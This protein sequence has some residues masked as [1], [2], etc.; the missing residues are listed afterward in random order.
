MTGPAISAP[1][2]SA[3]LADPSRLLPPASRLI[4]PFL[5]PLPAPTCARRMQRSPRQCPNAANSSL[6]RMSGR[7]PLK[8]SMSSM[9]VQRQRPREDVGRDGSVAATSQGC[10]GHQKLGGA[11]RSVPQNLR[12]QCGPANALLSD[13][14][15][16]ELR[17]NKLSPSLWQF[18]M[19][20]TGNQNSK[21]TGFGCPRVGG[22]HTISSR[23]AS[24]STWVEGRRAWTN[25]PNPSVPSG[26]SQPRQHS[27]RQRA[28]CL[29]TSLLLSP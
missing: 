11:G 9:Q 3:H 28:A 10:P 16:P 18:V 26:K 29:Q 7:F 1:Q 21:V 23:Q 25:E 12:G 24:C 20:A 5:S 2:G 27:T 17:E 13:S 8:E 6:K 15:P 22:S 19:V 14:W 4:G